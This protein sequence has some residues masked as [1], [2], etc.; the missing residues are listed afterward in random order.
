[1]QNQIG[2]RPVP[3]AT[4]PALSAKFH[5]LPDNSIGKVR[6]LL[7]ENPTLGNSPGKVRKLISENTVLVLGRRACCMC[8]VVKRLLLSLGVNPSVYDL[9]EEEEQQVE[10][11]LRSAFGDLKGGL[12]LVFIGGR[13]LGGLDSL[14]AAHI[15]GELVPILKQAGALWL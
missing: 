5:P 6:S 15:S 12:P 1:M 14:M 7:L 9:P 4:E 2:L 13:L 3:L 11:E 10:D 8:H